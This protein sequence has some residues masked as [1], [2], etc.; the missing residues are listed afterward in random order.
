MREIPPLFRRGSADSVLLCEGAAI[1]L[2]ARPNKDGVLLHRPPPYLVEPP[3]IG[4][5]IG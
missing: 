4:L 1:A 2:T 3:A 5:E